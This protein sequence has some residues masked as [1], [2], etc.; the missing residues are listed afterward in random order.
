MVQCSIVRTMSED[1]ET[2]FGIR[3]SIDTKLISKPDKFR[4]DSSVWLLWKF[5]VQNY[6]RLLN[7]GL[8]DRLDVA[9]TSDAEIQFGVMTDT[10]KSE[11]QEVYALLAQLLG[12]RALLDLMLV[13]D[14]NGYEAW[15]R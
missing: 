11:S 5:T 10:E 12:D 3:G 4:G 8:R 9:M 15:R 6:F 14:E 1:G 2:Y 7:P 13:P